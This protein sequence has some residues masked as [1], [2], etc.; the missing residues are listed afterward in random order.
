MGMTPG[1]HA[2]RLAPGSNAS[3]GV[4]GYKTMFLQNNDG[5]MQ[6]THSCAAGLDYVGVSPI[7]AHLADTKRVRFE[8]AT[9]KEVVD[10]LRL[11]MK[12][13]GLIPALESTHAFAQAIKEAPHLPKDAVLLINQSGRGDKDIFTVAEAI[14]DP[15]WFDFLRHKVE[16]Y[17]AQGR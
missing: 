17:N 16:L 13:E 10:S 12:T 2:A 9:D 11:V 4:S 7:L 14:G 15:K 3:I 1:E 5:Q 6:D 8:A